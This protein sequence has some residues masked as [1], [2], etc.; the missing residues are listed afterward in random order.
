MPADPNLSA[1]V[2][3]SLA[4]LQSSQASDLTGTGTGTKSAKGLKTEVSAVKSHMSFR[5]GSGPVARASPPPSEPLFRVGRG[6]V[7]LRTTGSRS[8]PLPF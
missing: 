7:M 3:Y 8:V 1:A 2:M 6:K 4:L 5:V